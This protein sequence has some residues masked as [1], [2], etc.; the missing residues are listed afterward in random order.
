MPYL[1]GEG[2][3]DD[4][5]ALRLDTRQRHH[6]RNVKKLDRHPDALAA[7]VKII[8]GAFNGAKCVSATAVY[9]CAGLVFGSRRTWIDV[10][11]SEWILREDD[12][13]RL[14]NSADWDV[15]DVVVYRNGD[16]IT[17]VARIRSIIRPIACGEIQVIVVSAWGESGEYVHPWRVVNPLLGTP[18]E[19]WSQRKAVA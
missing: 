19:V 6:I 7:G 4:K 3:P 8:E 2:G 9:N 5:N 10:E 12:F 13:V 11:I 16:A 18:T 14:P 17:H 1:I 15:G